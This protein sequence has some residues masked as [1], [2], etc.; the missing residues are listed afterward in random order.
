MRVVDLDSSCESNRAEADNWS[1]SAA[2]TDDDLHARTSSF[3]RDDQPASFRL[4]GAAAIPGQSTKS[5]VVV[6]C[7]PAGRYSPET[8]V[9]AGSVGLDA[10]RDLADFAVDR[11][12]DGLSCTNITG[13]SSNIARAYLDVNRPEDALDPAMFDEPVSAAKQSRKVMALFPGSSAVEQATVNR[14]AG[15]SNPSRGAKPSLIML[16]FISVDNQ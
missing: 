4:L 15:G 6:S 10:L 12:L 2:Y 13:I 3:T 1:A 8:L 11:L 9:T 7:P 5:A 14:L 16:P